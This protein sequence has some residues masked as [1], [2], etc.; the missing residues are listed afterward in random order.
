MFEGL[1]KEYIERLRNLF[2]AK[3]K[4]DEETGC[5]NWTASKD[6]DGYGRFGVRRTIK[7]AHRVSYTL[8]TGNITEG[9]HVLHKCDNPSCVNPDHLFL[10]T[11][12]ENMADKT[13][14]GRSPRGSKH[15][16]SK[17]TE[18]KVQ[19]IRYIH[20][21]LGTTQGNLAEIFNVNTDYIGRIV[22]RE[23]WKHVEDK[24]LLPDL[25]V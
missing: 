10:G 25:K 13:T 18:K 24:D 17:L 15:G 4:V 3:Y 6:G 2:E 22:R 1:T 8:H 23:Y 11:H 5:W 20:D 9:L 19:M 21:R 16:R 12:S 14:K 7:G